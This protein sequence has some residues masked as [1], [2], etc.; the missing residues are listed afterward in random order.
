MLQDQGSVDHTADPRT[1]EGA[2][3][4]VGHGQVK[5]NLVWISAH[6]GHAGEMSFARAASLQALIHHDLTPQKFYTRGH[7]DGRGSLMTSYSSSSVINKK[8]GTKSLLE[9]KSCAISF[10]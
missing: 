2:D 5:G 3:V 6:S 7:T 10:T 9:G 8:F 4:G 1:I